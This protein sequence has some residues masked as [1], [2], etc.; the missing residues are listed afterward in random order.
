MR[1]LVL[2]ALL[3]AIAAAEPRVVD[4][5]PWMVRVD[6]GI[7]SPV[8]FFGGVIGRTVQPGLALELGGGLGITGYQI[9]ALG[10]FYLPV[11]DSES[12]SWTFAGG[13]SVALMSQAWGLHVNHRDD[14]PIGS[15]DLFYMAMVNVEVGYELRMHWGGLLR[16]AVGGYLNLHETISP[17]CRHDPGSSMEPAGCEPSLEYPTAAEVARNRALPYF[18]FGYGFTW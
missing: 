13:P 14:L 1:A 6:G 11:G 8:G 16:V 17:L 7:G 2:I 15:G 5:R 18:V 10:R 9:A 4:E 3:P 12:S